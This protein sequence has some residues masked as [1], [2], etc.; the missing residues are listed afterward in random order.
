VQKAEQPLRQFARPFPVDERS[1]HAILET[2]PRGRDRVPTVLRVG[3]YSFGFFSNEGR[4]PP[5]VHVYAAEDQ[6]KFWLDPVALAWN[7]GFNSGEL[8]RISAI[9][10]EHQAELLEAWHEFFSE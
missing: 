4:E 3:R 7:Y 2:S 8:G 6:A 1:L 5:H 10:Q 9:I